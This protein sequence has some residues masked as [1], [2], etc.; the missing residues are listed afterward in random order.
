MY[1][2]RSWGKKKKKSEQFTTAYENFRTQSQELDRQAADITERENQEERKEGEDKGVKSV[3]GL[4][5]DK[6]T[7]QW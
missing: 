1:K 5:E 2:D 4:T 7:I 3:L 6:E